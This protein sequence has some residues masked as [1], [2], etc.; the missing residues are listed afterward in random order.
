M[1]MP[2][3]TVT[4]ARVRTFD[5]PRGAG[6]MALITLDNDKDHTRP[7]T[8]GPEGLMNLKAAMETI[9]ATPDLAAVAVTGKPFIFAVGADLSGTA[10]V[11]ERSQI[12]EFARFAHVR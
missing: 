5:M 8:F 2:I 3:E 1:S 11:T 12:L 6:R 9:K 10:H 4:F 7:T